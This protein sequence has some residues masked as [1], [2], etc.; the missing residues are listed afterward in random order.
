[1]E[2]LGAVRLLNRLQHLK[3]WVMS[4]ITP[5]ESEELY[6]ELDAD[7]KKNG[8][9]NEEELRPE[10]EELNKTAPVM[11]QENGEKGDFSLSAGASGC[12]QKWK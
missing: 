11:E 2:E 10:I 1:M 8:L 6:D 9:P 12:S 5:K 4:D 3:E 7:M